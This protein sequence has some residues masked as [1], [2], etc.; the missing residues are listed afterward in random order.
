MHAIWIDAHVW[1]HE[2]REHAV[3]LDNPNLH[4]AHRLA[5]GTSHT[6]P[7]GAPDHVVGAPPEIDPTTIGISFVDILFALVVGQVLDPV[8][9]WAV[10]PHE[11]PLPLAVV[12]HLVV[13]LVITTTSWI[14]YHNSANRARFKL[15][16][17]NVELAKFTLDIAM[18]V[19]YFLLASYAL[20]TPL[21]SRP[22]TLLVFI[23][24]VL[25]LLWDY[26]GVWQ[27]RGGVKNLYPAI[28]KQVQD[29]PTRHDIVEDWKPTDWRRIRATFWGLLATGI[30]FVVVRFCFSKATVT[31]MGSVV[32][33]AILLAILLL[34][35]VAKDR[36]AHR[37]AVDATREM[38]PNLGHA[39]DVARLAELDGQERCYEFPWP[40]ELTLDAFI[41]ELNV[42]AALAGINH[43]RARRWTAADPDD[44]AL[45]G[46]RRRARHR[47]AVLDLRNSPS[48]VCGWAAS[49]WVARGSNPEPGWRARHVDLRAETVT[50]ERSTRDEM[51]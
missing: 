18:V 2:R 5:A 34:Y 4:V 3:D 36:K 21:N 45:L 10:H 29:D 28:W 22:E 20:R 37:P 39:L 51:E 40:D 17:P 43:V 15:R 30:T 23:A 33:D 41:V 24:F 50:F 46:R 14:G 11:Q 13:A 7:A 26:A 38:T 49:G 32:V 12:V 44:G 9:K 6:R 48:S 1:M 31:S 42:R 16:F 35:R 19:V 25:Y 47:V 27:K 8:G